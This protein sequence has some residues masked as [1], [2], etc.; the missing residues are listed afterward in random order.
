[1]LPGSVLITVDDYSVIPGAIF[2]DVVGADDV[3][4]L[5]AA[6]ASGI[7]SVALMAVTLSSVDAAA[8][9]AA[10]EA[11][12]VAGFIGPELEADLGEDVM[13]DSLAA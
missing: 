1:M 9:E 12:A 6:A 7:A 8:G 13:I 4:E 10:A 2:Y 11:P 3:A 5:A